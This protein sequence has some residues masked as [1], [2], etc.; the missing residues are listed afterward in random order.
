MGFPLSIQPEPSSS[1]E[2]ASVSIPV[3]QNT[4]IGYAEYYLDSFPSGILLFAQS[5]DLSTV[6]W[7]INMDN[8][9]TSVQNNQNTTINIGKGIPGTHLTCLTNGDQV[10]QVFYQTNGT[11]IEQFESD[12]AAGWSMLDLPIPAS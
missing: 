6:G 2:T 4:S 1:Y 12:L 10:F 8:Q 7:N 3:F 9:T 5:P 11:N